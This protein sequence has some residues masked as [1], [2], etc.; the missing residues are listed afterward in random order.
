VKEEVGGKVLPVAMPEPKTRDEKTSIDSHTPKK[1]LP[2]RFWTRF[3]FGP[4]GKLLRDGLRKSNVYAI[5]P[6]QRVAKKRCKKRRL[7]IMVPN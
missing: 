7:F 1:N 6:T 3:C 2:Y 4:S 5:P